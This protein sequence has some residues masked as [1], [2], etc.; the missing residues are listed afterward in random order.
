[1]T[2][3]LILLPIS[4]V[5][6]SVTV[7]IYS[8]A[9]RLVIQPLAVVDIAVS[10]DEPSSTVGLVFLPVPLIDA[11]VAPNLISFS[12]SVVCDHIPLSL[13]SFT[14]WERYLLSGLALGGGAVRAVTRP[15]IFEAWKSRPDVLDA[16]SLGL[17]LLGIEV[18][19]LLSALSSHQICSEAVSGLHPFP[20]HKPSHSRLHFDD[21]NKRDRLSV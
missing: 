15:I 19:D 2:V 14:I 5:P 13:V 9:V 7:N 10:V 4:L 20:G 8:I 18:E 16:L 17:Q 6:S 12:I 21:E 3:L 1:M 11:A